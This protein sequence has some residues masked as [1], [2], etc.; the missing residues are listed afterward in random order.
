MHL[1][2]IFSADTRQ[3]NHI[4]NPIAIR[5]AKIAYRIQSLISKDKIE[6][7]L[8]HGMWNMAQHQQQLR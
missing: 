1:T 3:Q 2:R 8:H 4:N 6:Y 7:N 5:R